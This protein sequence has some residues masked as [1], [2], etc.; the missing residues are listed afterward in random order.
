[1]VYGNKGYSPEN[2][3]W[4]NRD[5]QNRNKCNNINIT[6]DGESKNIKDWCR[7]AG[8]KYKAV[9]PFYY[10]HGKDKSMATEYIKI[11]PW[12]MEKMNTPVMIACS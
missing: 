1:M 11:N 8:V 10:R 5:I 2:C 6:I 4:A 9:M 3:K 7:L 12:R